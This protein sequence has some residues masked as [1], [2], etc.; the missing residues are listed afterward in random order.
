MWI[1]AP[2]RHERALSH[3]DSGPFW[4]VAT[5]STCESKFQEGFPQELGLPR[6]RCGGYS[7]RR[8]EPFGTAH[9]VPDSS[10]VRLPLHR[11]QAEL[12]PADSRRLRFVSLLPR[13]LLRE[14][15]SRCEKMSAGPS[16]FVDFSIETRHNR[17]L[18][19]HDLIGS[20]RGRHCYAVSFFPR[21]RGLKIV[22]QRECGAQP[23]VARDDSPCGPITRHGPH[24]TE[25][26]SLT[27]R[28]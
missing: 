22:S 9:R 11:Y 5:R 18:D 8:L 21:I 7:P 12:A 3:D 28:N 16:R 24:T 14:I 20:E 17:P 10:H 1:Y 23:A 6:G 19:G 13:P 4:E 27:Q 25:T 26:R 2:I 15:C